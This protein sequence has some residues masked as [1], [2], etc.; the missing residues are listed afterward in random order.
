MPCQL[1]IEEEAYED[2]PEE[3]GV[4]APVPGPGVEHIWCK[5]AADYSDNVAFRKSV[6]SISAHGDSLTKDFVPAQQF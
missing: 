2:I 5:D 6:H 3:S 4:V 1:L